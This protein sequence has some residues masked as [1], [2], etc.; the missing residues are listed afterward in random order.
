MR[1]VGSDTRL[2]WVMHMIHKLG[3][4]SKGLRESTDK[5]TVILSVDSLNPCSSISGEPNMIRGG[6]GSDTRLR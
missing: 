6:K 3:L 2:R 5:I 1:A 4:G